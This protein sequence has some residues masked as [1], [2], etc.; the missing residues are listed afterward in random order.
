MSVM[1]LLGSVDNFLQIK[2]EVLDIVSHRLNEHNQIILQ[3]VDPDVEDWYTGIG[4][5]KHLANPNEIDYKYI[6]PSL[7]ETALDRLIS[8]YGAHRTRIMNMPARKCYSIHKDMSYRIHI[9]IVTT[10]MAWMVW[11]YEQACHNFLEGY[12][13]WT[14]TTLNHSFF[15]GAEVDRIHL[16]LCVNHEL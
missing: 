11:P 3:T 5:L 13:Y 16:V 15:N 2:Q 12:A 4:S 6:Q 14:N 9:P 7:K 1:K 8:K 10:S